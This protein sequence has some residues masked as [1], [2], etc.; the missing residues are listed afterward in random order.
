MPKLSDAQTSALGLINYWGEYDAKH[1]C[2]I[3]MPYASDQRTFTA[4]ERKG[5]V[6]YVRVDDGFRI[7]GYRLKNA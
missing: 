2:Y 5:Y 7:N 1:G 6:E 4:L 3:Y